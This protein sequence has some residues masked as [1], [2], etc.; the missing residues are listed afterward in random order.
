MVGM[1]LMAGGNGRGLREGLF[2][3]RE[4][5]GMRVSWFEIVG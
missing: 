4:N 1:E 3:M 2:E 5:D